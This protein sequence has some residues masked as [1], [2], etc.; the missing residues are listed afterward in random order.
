MAGRFVYWMNVSLDLFIE[1]EAGEHGDIEGPSWIRLS[2]PLHREFSARARAMPAMVEGRI[3]YEMMDPFWP[4]ART[5]ESLPGFLR[6]FRR[7]LDGYPQGAR[8]AHAH[9]GETQHAHHR[10][11]Q[12]RDR[13]ARR[14]AAGD[15]RRHRD[16][17]R[18]SRHAAAAGAPARRT[19][20]VHTPG[21][22]RRR[23][24]AFRRARPTPRTRPPG[25]AFIRP[26]R[27]NAPLR[28]ARGALA[29]SGRIVSSLKVFEQTRMGGFPAKLLSR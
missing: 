7:D 23:T 2:E 1:R 19:A 15:G 6:E 9:D 26:G 25:T 11:R 8:L 13:T 3:V 22:A 17:R 29:A 10:R 27:D 4:N 28:G 12:R 16:R 20:A 18:D 5:N 21:R 14:A 24:P